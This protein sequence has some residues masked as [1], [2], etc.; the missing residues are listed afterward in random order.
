MN[1][2][3]DSDDDSEFEG[4]EFVDINPD[5][6]CLFAGVSLIMV[7]CLGLALFRR[8]VWLFLQ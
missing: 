4:P 2:L 8:F 6:C 5:G 1:D 7:G 3:K